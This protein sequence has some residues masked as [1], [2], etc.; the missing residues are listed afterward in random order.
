VTR[1]SSDPR[2]AGSWQ[3]RW[4]MTWTASAD[5]PDE[6]FPALAAMCE[7]LG[8]EPLDL[9]GVA[10]NESGIHAGAHNRNGDAS[11]LW[12]LMPSTARGLG[13]QVASDP[14]LDAFRALGAVDQLPRFERYF[15][16]Y[17]G[18]L[19]SS[20]ACYV[21]TF[22]PALLPHAGDPTFV[23]CGSGGPLAWAYSANAG[24]DTGKTGVIRVSDLQA[25]VARAT[26]FLG[27]RWSEIV[28]RVNAVSPPDIAGVETATPAVLAT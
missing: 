4:A 13:W 17:R 28:T 20:G 26:K 15:N 2:Y 24:F 16:P 8:C 27:A 21:A 11:G 1:H 22:L 10:A 19:V 23:L 25:A 18:K 14:H 9:L 5:L 12:Q 6:F 7:R 3:R